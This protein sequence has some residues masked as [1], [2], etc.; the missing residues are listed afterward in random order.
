MEGEE[1]PD[2]SP[3]VGMSGNLAH[4]SKQSS[5]GVTS[6]TVTAALDTTDSNLTSSDTTR[7]PRFAL[8]V[9]PLHVR[10]SKSSPV[11]NYFKHFDLSFHPEKKCLHVCLICRAAGVNKAIS[12]GQSASTRPLIS[13]L[14]MHT[15]Q[16]LEYIEKKNAI[17]AQSKYAVTSSQSS[18]STFFPV[19]SSNRDLF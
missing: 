2:V 6:V 17:D 18:I 10:C 8:R 5:V 13:H 9:D 16:Y 7:V 19:I 11:W 4:H 1:D 15:D 3:A 14:R 12:V